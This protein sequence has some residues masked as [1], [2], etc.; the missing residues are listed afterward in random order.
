MEETQHGGGGAPIVAWS[1]P[2]M[3]LRGSSGAFAPLGAFARRSAD[4]TCGGHL[5]KTGSVALVVAKQPSAGFRSRD[6]AS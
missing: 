5:G 2:E 4:R 6:A 1:A 3:D